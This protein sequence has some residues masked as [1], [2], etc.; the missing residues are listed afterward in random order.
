LAEAQRQLT[1]PDNSQYHVLQA[2][3][4]GEHLVMRVQ[5][6]SCPKCAYEGIKTL[7]FLHVTAVQALQWKV[8]D[9]HFRPEPSAPHEAPSPAARFPGSD[10]G[11]NEA[12]RYTQG[13]S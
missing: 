1:G 3:E 5:Y 9:P 10:E 4:V 6:P 8:I 12:L 2:E 11:W 7:V 13:A